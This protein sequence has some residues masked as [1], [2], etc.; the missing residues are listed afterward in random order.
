M[1]PSSTSSL[2]NMVLVNNVHTGSNNVFRTAIIHKTMSSVL[3]YNAMKRRSLST[4]NNNNIKKQ[5]S[6]FS[7]TTTRRNYSSSSKDPFDAMF[8]W[9]ISKANTFLNICPQGEAM[10]VERFGKLHY[11]QRGGGIFFAIP[12]IDEIKYVIPLKEQALRIEPLHA[13]TADNVSVSV[14]G[15]L[16]AEF[17]NPER[18]AYG[19][20]NPLYAAVTHAQSV[21]RNSVGE[22]ELDEILKGRAKIN[23]RVVASIEHAVQDWGI[24]IKRYEVTEVNPEAVVKNSMDKQSAA[25]R[26]RRE[27]V[28]QAEGLKQAATLQSEGEKIKLVNESEGNLIRATNE[29][30]AAKRTLVMRAEGAALAMEKEAKATAEA[31][32]IIATALAKPN[33]DTAAT[34]EICKKLIAMH[35]EIGKAG[36]STYFFNE[37][38]AD[39]T[40]FMAQA[41]VILDNNKQQI[42]PPLSGKSNQVK[43]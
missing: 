28:L 43:F 12:F 16:Y 4:F 26:A 19:S 35:S 5:S 21:M 14:A 32:D 10:V 6:I 38:P 31:I 36:N 8:K 42:Q 15:N 17:V 7:T 25:E 34:L 20:V 30:E 39:L 1:L 13:I 23:A 33:A 41:K 29:A 27:Q 40:S 18:A 11:V 2:L 3:N 24:R 37:K 22:M 9:P